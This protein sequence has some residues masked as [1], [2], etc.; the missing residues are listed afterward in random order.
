M[1]TER[2]REDTPVFWSLLAGAWDQGYAA[3][4]GAYY[5]EASNPYRGVEWC[6][7][8][9]HEPPHHFEDCPLVDGGSA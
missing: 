4:T 3:G 6:R 5:G 7:S 8:C 9:H 2:K 1:S